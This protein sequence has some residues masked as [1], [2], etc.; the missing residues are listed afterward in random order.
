MD[1]LVRAA[2]GN[3]YRV[4]SCFL[5]SDNQNVRIM[6]IVE[7]LDLQLHVD[8]F[9]IGFH[10]DS[11]LAQKIN[12]LL[13]ILIMFRTDRNHRYLIRT[14]PEREA[15]LEVFDHDTYETLHGSEDSTVNHNRLFQC[16]VL[17]SVL[18][19]E[20][21]RQLEVKLDRAHLPFSSQRVL[22][23][24]VNLRAVESTVAFIDL[25]VSF[26]VFLKQNCLQV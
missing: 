22:H 1:T 7:A 16:S 26:P 25:K 4:F 5:V 23:L 9:V 14:C 6:H 12:N 10:T 18:H 8:I 15:S 2:D 20:V 24:Q 13:C 19:V 17:C 21:Q 11:V 3:G